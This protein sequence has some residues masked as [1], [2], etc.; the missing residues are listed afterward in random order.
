[1]NPFAS[2]GLEPRLALSDEEIRAAFRDAGKHSHPDSGGSGEAFARIQEAYARIASPSRRLRAWLDC[3]GIPGDERGTISPE[4]LDLFSHVGA[5]LQQADAIA[6]RRDG[7]LSALAKAMLEAE[8]QAAREQLEAKLETV[9][10]EIRRREERFVEIEA[11]AADGWLAARDL[12]FL[13]KWQASL[14]AAFAALW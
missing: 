14:R 1:M 13:E 2:L 11:G 10:G 7:S 8:A 4:L 6:K 5:A 3:K 9:A 12:A